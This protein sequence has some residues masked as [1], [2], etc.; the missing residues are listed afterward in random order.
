MENQRSLVL[1]Y[2]ILIVRIFSVRHGELLQ[3][4]SYQQQVLAGHWDQSSARLLQWISNREQ[5]E[6][7]SLL[8][9]GVRKWLQAEGRKCVRNGSMSEMGQ[10]KTINWNSWHATVHLPGH[11]RKKHKPSD[12]S[13]DQSHTAA[14]TPM[15]FLSLETKVTDTTL[16]IRTQHWKPEN[17][18][19]AR[20]NN[21]LH[22]VLVLDQ[23]FW[24]K[25]NS[26]FLSI[27]AF[28]RNRLAPLY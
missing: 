21:F 16:P 2:R 26:H 27:M 5:R 15:T 25:R 6:T 8:A 19:R 1:S 14:I 24:L 9:L 12:H 11:S 23:L 18:F 7:S 17:L 3:N 4:W 28:K 13:W 22:H 10:W 20:H